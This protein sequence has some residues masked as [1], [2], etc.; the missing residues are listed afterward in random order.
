[1]LA[2]VARQRLLEDLQDFLGLRRGGGWVLTGV[3]IAVH[4]GVGLPNLTAGEVDA[5]FD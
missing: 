4:D 2:G 5:Q 3:Q 1:M